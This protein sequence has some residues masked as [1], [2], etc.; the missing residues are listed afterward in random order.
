MSIGAKIGA[1]FAVGLVIIVAIGAS[2]YVSTQRLIE[3]NRL[4]MHTHVVL[5]SLEH[6]L[7][8]LREAETG[9]RG[10]ILTGED[11]YLEPYN[12]A[13]DE[14]QHDIDALGVLT[15][16]STAQQQCLERVRKLADA[17]LAE[18]RETIQLRKNSGLEA[19]QAVILNDRGKKIMDD[20]RGVVAE[21]EKRE[22]QLL[23]ER[24]NAVNASANRMIGTIAV[25]MPI[26]LLVLAV[27]AVTLMRTVQ[28]GGPAAPTSAPSEKWSRIAVQYISAV[29]VVVVAVELR[30]RLEASFGPLPLFLTFYPAVLLIASIGG[31]GPGIVTT[32]LS[33]LA[34]DY[35]FVRP[36]GSFGVEGPNDALALGIFTGFGVFASVL[37]ERLRRTRWAEAVAVAQEREL[38]ELSRLNEELSQQSEELSQQSEELSQQS[39]EVAHQNEELQTQSEEIQTLNTELVYRENTLR[40]LL[41][42]ARLPTTEQAV[43][44]VICSAAHEMFGLANSAVMVFEQRGERLV[45]RGQAGLG[46]DGA[47]FDEWPTEHSFAEVVIGANKTACLADASLRPD[48]S[49]A[50]A[51]GEQP[52]QSVLA[53][54]MRAKGRPF[55][56]VAIYSRQKQEWTA[57]Q[58]RLAEWLAAQCAKILETL[59]LQGELRRL[60]AEQQMIFNSVPAMIWYKDTKNNFI[61]V[62][63]AVASALGKPLDAIEGKSADELFPKDAE[64]Y[65]QDDLE[66][67]KSGEPKLGILETLEN[68]AGEKRWVQTDKIPYRGEGGDIAGVLVFAVD[69]TDRKLADEEIRQAKEDWERTFDSVPDL[70]AILDERHGVT[71][72]NAAM[73]RAMGLKPEECIGQRCFR[74]VH[75]ADQPPPSCPHSRTLADGRPHVAEV[76][77]ERL[78]GDFLVTTTPMFDAAGKLTGTVHIA[79]DITEQKRAEMELHKSNET[80]ERQV[81]ERTA[82]IEQHARH[83]RQLAAELSQ[84]EHRERKR[85]AAILHDNL[86]QLLLAARLRLASVGRGNR[87]VLHVEVGAVDE[88]LDECLAAS[89]DLTMD[90]SPPILHRGALGEV[91]EWLGDWFGE[92]HGLTVTVEA[93]EELPSVPEHIHV[94]LF[95]AVRELLFNTVKHSGVL[96]A[97]V[98]VSS[99]DG[100]LTVQ[101]EDRGSGFDPKAV[102]QSLNR[103]RSFGLFNIQERLEALDGR[104]EIDRTPSG[105]ACFRVIVPIP[106]IT[107]SLR[108]PLPAV[109]T[110]A[111]S[112]TAEVP[113]SE[114][115]AIRLLVVDDHKVV[116]EGFVGLLSREP[117]FEVIGQA[118][119]GKEAVRQAEAL[120]PDVIIMDVEMPI[121]DGIEATRRIKQRQPHVVIVGLS[122]HEEESVSR[123]IM[124]AGAAVHLSKHS[125]AE[126]LVAAIRRAYVR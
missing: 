117:G 36:Y 73:A 31:G 95:Q 2:A 58:F 80:L 39:E 105:G 90:L 115:A 12:A 30:W 61:R 82:V 93:K 10:F 23:N 19:A 41:D 98:F 37:A 48:I 50:H 54:P 96:E 1:G 110:D 9:Q 14:I 17:K 40:K 85:L 68:A 33:A 35:W 32:V 86:Q 59:R 78:G 120:R 22:R 79:R 101:V 15:R 97:Q 16:D 53:A 113:R 102:Q 122:L 28:F 125:P 94:F 60:Y 11:R 20:L 107:E 25:W 8:V 45:V 89:R 118:A 34:V 6:V 106:T 7:S 67:I 70:I 69:V 75:G 83:L 121:M 126:E 109:P 66:V 63:R 13:T 56:S 81:A 5:E 114:A 99:N 44:R 21:M 62:N 18:L 71:R 100:C 29:V 91:F 55:G 26:A 74:C 92:K 38:E 64:Q 57:D 72:V 119:D 124:D 103:S 46:P 108:E 47:N 42:A 112:S 76:Y 49:L 111:A 24:N 52:F 84:T 123:A 87:G 88:L 4:V 51:P 77:E 116:R 3:A 43:I 27:V 65:Y 104:L